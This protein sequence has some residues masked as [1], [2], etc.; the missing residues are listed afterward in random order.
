MFT[1]NNIE[2]GR[3]DADVLA[4]SRHPF[5]DILLEKSFQNHTC[6][7]LD[8]VGAAARTACKRGLRNPNETPGII[9]WRHTAAGMAGRH[10]FLG[11]N[12][13]QISRAAGRIMW[14]GL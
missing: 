13:A 10:V 8:G 12:L 7:E 2:P 5:G 6:G 14:A 9:N 3:F 1:K 4:Y 11:R